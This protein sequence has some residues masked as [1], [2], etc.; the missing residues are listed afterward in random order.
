MLEVFTGE[1]AYD[2]NREGGQFL[3]RIHTKNLLTDL[4]LP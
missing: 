4:F 1:A 2:E 3:V